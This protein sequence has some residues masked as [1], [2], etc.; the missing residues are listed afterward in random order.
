[1]RLRRFAAALCVIPMFALAAAA[2]D[3][4]LPAPAAAR[5]DAF[6]KVAWGER[7][8]PE[9]PD[10]AP[11]GWLARLEA[12]WALSTLS[13]ADGKALV[14]LVADPDRFVRAVAARAAGIVQPEGAG[15][16]LAAALAA[17]KEKMVRIAQIEALAR[18]GGPG[19]LEAVEAQQVP[20]ADADVV[21]H[22]GLARRQLKGGKWDVDSLRGESQEALRAKPSSAKIDAPAPEL[23]LPGVAGPVNLSTFKDKVVLLAFTHGDRGAADQKALARLQQE[24]AALERMGVVV[25]AV[26]PQEK[27]RVKIWAEKAKLPVTFA[28]DPSGRAQAAYGVARQLFVAGEWMPSPGWFVIDRGGVLRWSK[29]G[30]KP[31]EQA[32]LGELL[33]VLDAVSRGMKPPAR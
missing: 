33:P 30:R 20:G 1:M 11:E 29:V 7:L 28:A 6:R 23:A 32:S 24:S 17:E 8:R 16:A 13:G 3:P 26:A 31:D 4:Q 9:R 21:F 14:A 12:E 19:A 2:A 10:P 5:L 15:P 22:V 27:E 25:V 18:I